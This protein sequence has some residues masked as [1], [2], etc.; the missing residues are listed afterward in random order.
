[1]FR[2]IQWA[3]GTVGQSAIKAIVGRDD[4]QLVGCY[5]TSDAKSGRDAGE[6][7]GTGLTGVTATTDKA[8]IIAMPAD[9]V[10]YVPILH[11]ID[12]ICALLES[13]K[14]VVTGCPY[15][16][17][18]SGPERERIVGACRKGGSTLLGGGIAPGQL[19]IVLPMLMSTLSTNIRHI[20]VKEGGKPA[21]YPSPLLVGERMKFGR[22]LEDAYDNPN[23][24]G[25]VL[26]WYSQ[27]LQLICGRMGFAIDEEIC[28]RHQVW[29]AT[30]DFDTPIGFIKK[31]TAGAQLF[32]V[33]ATARGQP[34]FTYT[35]YWPSGAP[36]ECSIAI[37]R[38]WEV[39]IEGDPTLTWSCR[40]FEAAFQGQ[41]D[42]PVVRA[43]ANCLVNAVPQ[44]CEAAPGF[45]TL[46]EL[47]PMSGRADAGLGRGQ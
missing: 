8:G 33:Q 18:P 22:S 19:T 13:G 39:E 16:F 29:A 28:S 36:T 10:I 47:P 27:S 12:D 15:N 25:W 44:T 6:I 23:L 20:H 14:N 41:M 24:R 11:D 38:G 45:A 42:P 34:V 3:T 4:M 1:M 40:G 2:V 9:C 5:V 46:A 32:E 43:T 37:E 17:I 26:P 21:E 31:G 7:A 30:E 35:K